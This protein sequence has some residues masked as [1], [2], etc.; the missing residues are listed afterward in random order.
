MISKRDGT[1]DLG[2]KP[3][4]GKEMSQDN[5]GSDEINELIKKREHQNK[6][7]RKL[8]ENIGNQKSHVQNKKK[9]K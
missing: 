1:D 7:L 5:S 4:S 6:V 9:N 8:I 3:L 2:K